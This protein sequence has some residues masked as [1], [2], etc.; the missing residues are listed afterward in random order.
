[1]FYPILADLVVFTHL[2]FI[3][4]AALGAFL[5]LRW[6]WILWLHLPALFWAVWIEFSGGICPLTPLENWLRIRGG[7]GGYKGDFVE[8]YVLPILYPTGLTRDMQFLLGM[9]V[10]VINLVIYGFII[11]NIKRKRTNKEKIH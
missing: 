7:R 4:F 3:I 10:I 11:F 8:T 6:H 9:L 1:M 2:G 5:I